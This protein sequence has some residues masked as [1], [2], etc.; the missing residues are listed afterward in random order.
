MISVTDIRQKYK[1]LSRLMDERSRRIW[2]A[3]EARAMGWG[4][5]SRVA[6]AIGMARN[7]IA[8]GL[9]E[10]KRRGRRPKLKRVRRTGGGRK[11]VTEHQPTLVKNL[12]ALVEPT[13]RGDPQSP[14]RW[15]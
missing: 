6:E 13:T 3:T 15:T 1:R 14:L 11:R 4:G 7:T 12:E 2:A 8:A 10:L 9:R 5:V